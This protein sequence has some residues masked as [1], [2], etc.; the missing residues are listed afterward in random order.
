[1][2]KIYSE[3]EEQTELFA[4]KIAG[5]LKYVPQD[6]TLIAQAKMMGISFGDD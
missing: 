5:K 6:C 1:M 2:T 3:S 4:Q